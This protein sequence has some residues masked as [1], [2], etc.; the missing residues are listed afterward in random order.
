M[1][2]LAWLLI[3]FGIAAPIVTIYL[4]GAAPRAA[5][6]ASGTGYLLSI[7]AIIGVIALARTMARASRIRAFFV[8]AAVILVVN[9]WSSIKIAQGARID[10]EV[11]A[12]RPEINAIMQAAATEATLI[13]TGQIAHTD[14]SPAWQAHATATQAVDFQ[15]STLA[16][17][18]R[19]VE[20][21]RGEVEASGIATA[22]SPE[23]LGSAQ[24][25]ADSLVRVAR[26]KDFIA[27]YAERL[28]GLSR[29]VEADIRT[30]GLPHASEAEMI[31]GQ[32]RRSRENA[33]TFDGFIDQEIQVVDSITAV[34]RFV[35]TNAGTAR[36]EGGLLQF[37]DPNVQAEYDAM[38]GR[39][40]TEKI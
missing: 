36:V 15:D 1:A 26:Y 13:N 27:T 33:A 22:L 19:L 9:G 4:S 40:T 10:R 30:L 21:M 23:R 5:G 37:S 24:D 8:V 11:A 2:L 12:A 17:R 14:V 16:L 32:L 28:A 25:R 34:I 3:A 38:V 20:L 39:L 35:E 18:L 31:A 7:I 29:E 6:Y